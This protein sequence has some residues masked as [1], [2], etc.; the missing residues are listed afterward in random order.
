MSSLIDELPGAL[1]SPALSVY[2]HDMNT[3]TCRMEWFDGYLGAHLRRFA[4][5]MHVMSGQSRFY[6]IAA[7]LSKLLAT[8][9]YWLC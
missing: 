3:P 2:W 7:G 9:M 5:I 4:P 8:Y 1:P 6:V